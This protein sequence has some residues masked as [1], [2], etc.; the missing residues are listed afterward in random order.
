[1]TRKFLLVLGFLT[2]FSST[3]ACG[4]TAADIHAKYGKS[5]EVYSVSEHIWMTPDY[6]SDGQICRMRLYTKRIGENTNYGTHNLPFNE[7]RDFLNVLVPS[8]TRG[9][10]KESF[11]ATATGGGA[12]WT[13]YGYESVTFTFTSFFSS[14]SFEGQTLKR[15]EYVFPRLQN[16]PSS[17]ES[18][19]SSNDFDHSSSMSIE[20]VTVR[21]NGRKCA[22]P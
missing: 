17:N 1:M 2:T 18:N 10:K 8:E 21:W 11:G 5:L 15:G 9:A 4:Q 13:T 19:S 6:A 7:L 16:E 22:G 14:R 20:I 3:H 12:A